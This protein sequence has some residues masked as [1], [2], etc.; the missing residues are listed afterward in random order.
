MGYVI[1]F[2]LGFFVVLLVLNEK[3]ILCIPFQSW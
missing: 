2:I 3:K 1:Y